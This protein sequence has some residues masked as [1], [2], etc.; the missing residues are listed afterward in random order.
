M[1]VR[2]NRWALKAVSK[3]FRMAASP[4]QGGEEHQKR[5]IPMKSSR[6][7]LKSTTRTIWMATA[8]LTCSSLVN[9]QASWQYTAGQS[10]TQI[11]ED[12]DTSGSSG[13]S[14]SWSTA[15][16][17]YFWQASVGSG[18]VSA[19]IELEVSS[20]V[21]MNARESLSKSVYSGAY[22]YAYAY[23]YWVGLPGASPSR[24]A[25]LSMYMNG[26]VS[27]S[28]SGSSSAGSSTSQGMAHADGFAYTQAN[29]M[30]GSGDGW[31]EITGNH[32][33]SSGTANVNLYYPGAAWI[34]D[35]NGSYTTGSSWNIYAY[36]YFYFDGYYY[37][38]AG[39]PSIYATT[40]GYADCSAA[41]S[42]NPTPQSPG[43]AE[44]AN[45]NT[46]G[47][48]YGTASVTF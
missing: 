25:H 18:G 10:G 2:N 9:N 3:V 12:V 20:G 48:L 22:A 31:C 11:H 30:W 38:S 8:I 28:G 40:G 29:S 33:S 19:D 43:G 14:M 24:T 44:M 36:F 45:A 47:Y 13:N 39:A 27:G 4:N 37:T 1:G 42:A 26:Y 34:D 46:Y 32:N 15:A 23:W 35:W 16:Y 7:T 21:S 41:A 6:L 17:A 5:R